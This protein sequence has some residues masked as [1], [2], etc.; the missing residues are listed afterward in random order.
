MQ[1]DIITIFPKLFQSFLN[2]SLIKKSLDKKVNKICV[3]NLRDFTLGKHRQVDDSPYG[4]GAG[5]IMMAEPII[6]A[7]EKI[8]KQNKAS[9]KFK[10]Q[11]ILLS[12]AGKQLD[13]AQVKKFSH[14]DQL[15]LICGRYQG[16][17][18]RVA[19]IVDAQISIGHYV[20][21][22]GE[23][24]AMVL[25]E[26]VARLI[27]G[28]LGNPNSLRNETKLKGPYRRLAA[29]QY[30][31]PEKIKIQNKIYSVPPVLL[32]G[33]HQKIAAWEKE[34]SKIK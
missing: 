7:V 20:L 30:T 15:I 34:H 26:A 1:F 12:P 31:R 17:D 33:D 8:K 16:V 27:P 13:Q 2:E 11:V 23:L 32:S 3:H 22:G 5:M 18:A 25:T 6:H 29:P 19:T 14:V 28:Y 24:P 4:G 10:S 9:K 21:S